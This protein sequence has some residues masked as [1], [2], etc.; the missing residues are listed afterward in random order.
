MRPVCTTIICCSGTEIVEIYNELGLC[1]MAK[2]EYQ[3]ALAAFQAEYES[4]ETA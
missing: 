4:K 3:N 2:K 1:E